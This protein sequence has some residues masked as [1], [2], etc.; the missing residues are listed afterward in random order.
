MLTCGKA[1]TPALNLNP[2]CRYNILYCFQCN[3]TFLLLFSVTGSFLHGGNMQ[4][5]KFGALSLP[6]TGVKMEPAM[7][8]HSTSMFS[9]TYFIKHK[10]LTEENMTLKTSTLY[11]MCLSYSDILYFGLML[12][13]SH[14]D[15]YSFENDLCPHKHIG[16]ISVLIPAHHWEN[17]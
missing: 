9:E 3:R 12:S 6:D 5:K 15:T 10:C 16:P 7:I 13:Y 2:S 4:R 8:L 17:I 11:R 14:T 1:L